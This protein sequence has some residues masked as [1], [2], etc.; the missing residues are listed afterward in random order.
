[1]TMAKRLAALAMVC[2]LSPGSL[3]A[4]QKVDLELV[5][6]ADA[7]RSIDDEEIRLQRE[8]YAAAFSH[9]QVLGAITS[10]LHRRIAVTYVEW[11]SAESQDIVV[12]WTIIEGPRSAAAFIAALRSSPRIANGPNAIGSAIATGH[13]LIEAN[14]LQGTRRIIDFSGDSAYSF[15]GI[16][17]DQA[18]V[19]ALGDGITINGLAILCRTPGCS[20]RPVGYDLEE[21][22]RR[23]I[24]GGPGAFVVTADGNQSFAE[25]VLRKLLLEVAGVSP[26]GRVAGGEG[27]EMAL[28]PPQS[29]SPE[30][31]AS[32]AFQRERPIS[33]LSGSRPINAAP[34]AAPRQ[35]LASRSP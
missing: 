34:L 6:L 22:Y 10:G 33:S 26:P 21:A 17:V 29:S 15:G 32:I 16:P 25:A 1:M 7:S 30:A 3:A 24:I 5:L 14:D 12:P 35:P 18:R 8:G 20:G 27:L 31:A 9:A 11:G 2:L 13:A 4:T 19:L 23:Y 28:S